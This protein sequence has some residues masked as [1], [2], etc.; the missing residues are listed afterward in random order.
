[1]IAIGVIPVQLVIVTIVLGIHRLVHRKPPRPL[2]IRGDS[3]PPTQQSPLYL[4]PKAELEDDP[5]RKHELDSEHPVRELDGVGEILE[6]AD[7]MVDTV[8]ILQRRE[9]I[10]EMPHQERAEVIGDEIAQEL[11]CPIQGREDFVKAQNF[12]MLEYPIRAGSESMVS[13]FAKELERLVQARE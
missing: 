9:A 6:I 10:S 11:E 1:M 13:E 3:A 4:Q 8:P 2:Q 5:T 7:E 12:G